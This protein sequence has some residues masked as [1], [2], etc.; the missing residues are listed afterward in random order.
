MVQSPETLEKLPNGKEKSEKRLCRIK[1][2][3]FLVTNL[4]LPDALYT[5]KGFNDQIRTLNLY[6][7]NNVCL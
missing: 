2:T 5:G 4:Q 6:E 7:D 3:Y 1:H